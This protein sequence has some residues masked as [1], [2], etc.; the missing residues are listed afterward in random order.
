MRIH[1]LIMKQQFY[2]IIALVFRQ[3]QRRGKNKRT[4]GFVQKNFK[5]REKKKKKNHKLDIEHQMKL[6]IANVNDNNK[7]FTFVNEDG[8]D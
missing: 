7:L 6:K 8:G 1:T 3:G 5:N 2:K 4:F